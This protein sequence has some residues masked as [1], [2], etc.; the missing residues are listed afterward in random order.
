MTANS[1][2]EIVLTGELLTL[3]EARRLDELEQVVE[4]GLTVFVKVGNALLEIRDS[5]LYRQQ[6]PTFEAYCRERWG[7]ERR[8]AYRLIDAAEVVSNV[9]QGTQSHQVIH[10]LRR[11]AKASP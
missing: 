9:S 2:A 4:T 6:F 10:S 11:I 5:R 1:V 7:I 3:D 8:Q